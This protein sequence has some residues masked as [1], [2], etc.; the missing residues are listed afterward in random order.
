MTKSSDAMNDLIRQ[1]PRP[2]RRGKKAPAATTTTSPT[3]TRAEF[4]AWAAGVDERRREREA[5][6]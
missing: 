6:H 3:M 2:G 5:G 1:R 4:N